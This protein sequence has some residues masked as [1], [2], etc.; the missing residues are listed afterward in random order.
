MSGAFVPAFRPLLLAVVLGVAACGG[1]KDA[2]TTDAAGQLVFANAGEAGKALHEAARLRDTAA[3]ARILG[4]VSSDLLGWGDPAGDSASLAS[5][6]AKYDQIHRW[7]RMENGTEVLHIG[8]DNFPFPIPLLRGDSARW[9]FDA[10]AGQKELLARRIGRGEL[11][12]IDATT[13]IANAEELYFQQSHD[14]NPRHQ[15]TTKILSTPG[16]QDGLY[17]RVPADQ[18]SSPLGRLEQFAP[19][20]TSTSPAA[21]P[22]FDGYSFRIL[23]AQGAAAKGGAKNYLAGGKLTRGFAVLATPIRYGESGVMTFMISREGVV[24]ESD[25]GPDTRARA[26]AITEYNP[27][28]GWVRVD[29]SPEEVGS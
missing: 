12:A 7:V 9:R 2:V 18:P 29:N 15:Y 19:A 20:V 28:D 10:T 14:G 4:P 23:T 24:Y 27:A 1:R 26:A 22:E 13:S 16:T 5:F 3:I 11:L 6:S 21:A 8:A 25:L 17:W